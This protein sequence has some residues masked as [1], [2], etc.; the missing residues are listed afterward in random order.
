MCI[1]YARWYRENCSREASS[2]NITEDACRPLDFNPELKPE[3][4]VRGSFPRER[5]VPFAVRVVSELDV[6]GVK[7]LNERRRLQ[8]VTCP[9]EVRSLL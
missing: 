3:L 7:L 4:L 2:V 1:E 8:E 5:E 6:E 9:P